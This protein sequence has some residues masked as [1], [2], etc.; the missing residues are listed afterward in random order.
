MLN[1]MFTH[2]RHVEEKKK[3]NKHTKSAVYKISEYIAFLRKQRKRRKTFTAT[4]LK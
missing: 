1:L 4:C 2:H 3:R